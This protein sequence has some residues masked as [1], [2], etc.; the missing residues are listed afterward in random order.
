MKISGRVIGAEGIQANLVR[1]PERIKRAVREEIVRSATELAARAR[2]LAP[3][4]T[5][6]L[7]QSITVALDESPTRIRAVVG[8]DLFY[9]RFQEEGFKPNPRTKTGWMRNSKRNRIY[10]LATKALGQ[11]VKNPFLGP[12]FSQMQAGIRARI[13]A[14]VAGEVARVS[15]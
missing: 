4:E 14:A 11:R 2:G 10:N 8:S 15:P 7:R 3:V 13:R 5:G 6:E 1:M 9:S 12:A